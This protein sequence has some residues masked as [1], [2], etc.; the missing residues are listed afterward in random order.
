MLDGFAGSGTTILAAERTGRCGCGIELEP[1]YVDVAIRRW[2]QMTGG[3]ARHAETGR[4]FD[5][6]GRLA[7]PERRL[8]L[9]AP[10]GGGR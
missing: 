5:E 1:A 2:Q 8:A 10:V 4:R 7:A 9:P 6:V 3:V